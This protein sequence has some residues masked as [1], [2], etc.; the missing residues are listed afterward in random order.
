M[1]KWILLIVPLLFLYNDLYAQDLVGCTQLL[2]D[3]REAYEGGMVELVPELLLDCI[4]TGLSGTAK[5]E[6]YK[7]VINAYLFDYLP[8]L[9]DSLMGDFLDDFP[10]YR[11]RSEDPAEF[12]LLLNTHLERRAEEQRRSEEREQARL[13]QLQRER[14]RLERLQR[15]REEQQ[16]KPVQREEPVKK[17]KRTERETGTGLGFTLGV[18]GTFP[19]I[20]EP[21]STSDPLLDEGGYAMAVPGFRMGMIVNL[22]ISKVFETDIG[23]C[24]NRS[25]LR[26]Q[27]SPFSFS[28]YELK[29][30]ESHLEI[31]VSMA[32]ILNPVSRTNVYLRLGVAAK[33][34]IS[35]SAEATRSYSGNGSFFLRDVVV[36]K[37]ELNDSRT[38]LNLDALGGLGVRFSLGNASLFLETRFQYGLFNANREDNRYTNQDLIWLIYH[39]DSDYRINHLSLNAGMRWTL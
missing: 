20:L 26:Y 23:I 29:E 22:P 13:E 1:R 17:Q 3:A 16:E 38:Q 19:R 39:V 24:F 18:N 37:T 30:T 34:L 25:R 5:Q 15:E 32:F 21:F 36:E 31:P 6:A 9:A 2:E 33:Y 11:A 35:A 27:S 14:E 8:E 4:E 12:E 10:D 7:L 28:S